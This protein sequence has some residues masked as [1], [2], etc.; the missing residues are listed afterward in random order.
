MDPLTLD[1]GSTALL[2]VDV[3]EKLAPAMPEFDR[4]RLIA[5]VELL[6]DTA[7]AFRLPIFVTEQYP[8][9]LGRTLEPVR[10]LL[11]SCS[12]RPV[13]AEKTVFSATAPAEIVRGLAASG[14][15]AVIV[16]GMEAHVCVF[17]TA[18]DLR[19]RGYY[20][21]VPFDAVASRDPE[22]RKTALSLLGSHGVS[23]TTTE[24]VVF[25][26]LHDAQNPKF[27]A[28]SARVKNLPLAATNPTSR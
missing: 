17:Q 2:I 11:E 8:K 7:R 6:A 16:V 27:R 14:V 4:Q 5:C 1:P 28:L 20:V 18:R 21:H 23:V 22:C 9:G 13:V 26:L 10:A 15:R 3:Q 12:P 19:T 25:D 24:T